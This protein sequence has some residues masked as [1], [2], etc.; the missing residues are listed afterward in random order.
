MLQF[1]HSLYAHWSNKAEECYINWFYNHTPINTALEQIGM[2]TDADKQ[3]FK[4]FCTNYNTKYS[5]M[6]D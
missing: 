4:E 5:A 1:H 3:L 2:L 6:F